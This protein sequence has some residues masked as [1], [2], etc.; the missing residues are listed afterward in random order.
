MR[1]VVDLSPGTQ[2]RAGTTGWIY[3]VQGESDERVIVSGPRG[4]MGVDR[5]ELQQRIARGRVEVLN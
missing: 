3:T 5:D 2:L 4:S 1:D